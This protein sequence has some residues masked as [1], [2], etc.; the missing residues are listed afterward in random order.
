MKFHLTQTSLATLNEKSRLI[1]Y[2]SNIFTKTVFLVYPSLHRLTMYFK[3]ARGGMVVHVPIEIENVDSDQYFD[4]D[5]TK[6][7]NAVSKFSG[8]DSIEVNITPKQLK[9]MGTYP[10]VIALGIT[11]LPTEPDIEHALQPP[12]DAVGVPIAYSPQLGDTLAVTQGLFQSAGANNAVQLYEQSVMYSDRSLVAEFFTAPTGVPEHG[13]PLLRALAGFMLLASRF[14]HTFTLYPSRSMLKWSAD[15]IEA[16]VASEPVNI[17]LPSADDLENI[18]P[19]TVSS[20]YGRISV[21]VSNLSESLKFFNGFYE[22]SAWKPIRLVVDV[23]VARLEYNHPTT[24]ISKALTIL[25]HVGTPVNV[26]VSAEALENLLIVDNGT[27]TIQYDYESPGVRA[28]V[29]D[30]EGQAAVDAVLSKLQE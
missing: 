7:S 23:D 16:L 30:T 24:Q 28:V 18:R 17:A 15:G 27:V 26:L 6:W 1:S 8:L 13:Q 3:G 14:S 9:I 25:E 21:P 20:T 10:D 29:Q 5:Y 4:I 22:A 11:K 12:D 2:T 19:D